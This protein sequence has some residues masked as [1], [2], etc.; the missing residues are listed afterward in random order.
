ME[1]GVWSLEALAVRTPTNERSKEKKKKKRLRVL[2][3]DA[4]V[5]HWWWGWCVGT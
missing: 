2:H 1:Y 3:L 5:V 4:F